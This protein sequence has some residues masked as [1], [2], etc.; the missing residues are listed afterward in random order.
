MM[1]GPSGLRHGCRPQ[2]R[3]QARGRVGPDPSERQ[4]SIIARRE[5]PRMSILS[6]WRRGRSAA[7]ASALTVVTLSSSA[8]AAKDEAPQR[9]TGDSQGTVH[10]DGLAV[11]VSEYLSPEARALLV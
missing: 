2:A 9:V 4:I 3:N 8:I 6:H 1:P 10:A 7:L 5:L 11:P